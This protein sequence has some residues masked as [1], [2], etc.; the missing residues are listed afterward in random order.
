MP[1]LDNQL[2]IVCGDLIPSCSAISRCV[3]PRAASAK[4][5]DTARLLRR[6]RDNERR[7]CEIRLRAERKAGELLRERERAKGAA[8]NPGG[9][10]AP[11]VRSHGTTAQ[12][13]LAELGISKDQ[14]SKWQQLAAVPDDDDEPELPIE[15]SAAVAA[16]ELPHSC[17]EV[18]PK[19]ETREAAAQLAGFGSR[20]EYRRAK[21]VVERGTPELVAKMDRPPFLR[22]RFFGHD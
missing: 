4:A 7:A 12:K 5:I 21:T 11:I 19:Q 6:S 16:A 1:E 17:A 3:Q 10:G 9:R 2:P 15:G 20:E 18:K 8:G 13:T 22:E 14:S